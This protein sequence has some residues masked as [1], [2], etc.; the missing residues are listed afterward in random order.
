[1]TAKQLTF[2]T[3]VVD[4]TINGSVHVRFNPADVSFTEAFYNAFMQLDGMQEQ[5]QEEI[6]AIGDDKGEFFAYARKR[7]ADMRAI[8]DGL[9][10]EGVADAL[11]PGINCYAI[12]DGLPIWVNFLFAIAE[13]IRDAYDEER[14]KSD[15]RMKQFDAKNQALLEKYRKATTKNA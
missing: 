6:R 14:A 13:E 12:A 8:I 3:G 1:M 9:F 4:Y 15:P 7:D 11:F 5:F 10:G 2:N